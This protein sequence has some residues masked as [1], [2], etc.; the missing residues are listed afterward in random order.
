VSLEGRIPATTAQALEAMGHKVQMG[1]DWSNASA[2][3]VIVTKEGALHGGSDP[4]RGRFIFG[5]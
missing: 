5:R 3:V 1:G 2:P 4:R